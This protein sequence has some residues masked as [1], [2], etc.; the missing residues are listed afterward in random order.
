MTDSVATAKHILATC[1]VGLAPGR[2]FGPHGEGHLRLCFAQPPETL[3]R[4]LERLADYF[5]GTAA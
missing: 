5:S 4:A 2:A 1:G 3:T